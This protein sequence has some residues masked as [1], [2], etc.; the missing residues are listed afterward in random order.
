M[1]D[2][3]N[4]GLAFVL[5]FL[6]L[7]VV[8]AAPGLT[9]VADP[10]VVFVH[11]N[12]D[13]AAL[14]H[15]TIWRFESNG[16]PRDRLFAIDLRFPNARTVDATPQVGRTSADEARAFLVSV[17]DDR[18]YALWLLALSR[19]PRRGERAGLRWVDVDSENLS[20]RVYARFTGELGR[21]KSRRSRTV[22]MVEE[23]AE[24]LTKLGERGHN[25]VKD[26][27]VFQGVYDGI[28]Y[29][30]A[31]RRRY[32]LEVKRA[33]FP[34]LRLHALRHTFIS[35][36]DSHASIVQVRN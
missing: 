21:T 3:K 4:L 29:P 18:L 26:D 6:A 11:G 17:A 19:G 13:T 25:T 12:G 22:P 14:W 7:A 8:T 9:Q 1:L 34:P 23:V 35:F 5:I 10:P 27:F 30:S 2:R 28:D 32:L 15:T 31:L 33:T 24:A 16:Y 20:I 36:A